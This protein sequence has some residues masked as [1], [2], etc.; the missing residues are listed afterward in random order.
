MAGRT[1]WT[2]GNGAGLTWTAMFGT[3]DLT[4]LANGASVMSSATA[5][6]NG[7]NL[8]QLADVSVEITISSATPT[9]GANIT[10][11]LAPLAQDGSTYGD[12][13][14]T[15]GTQ[16]SA[17]TPAWFSVQTCPVQSAAATTKMIAYFQGIPLP[18]V[19]FT[20]VIQNNTGQ[21]FSSTAANNVAKFITY[22]VND[23]N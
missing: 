6:A 17:Y 16:K 3:A 1:A 18:P 10:L 21:A 8:D 22:N 19:S 13:S 15:A 4:S 5:I 12:G 23:N 7:T 9:A 20:W 14:F 11:W 2:A